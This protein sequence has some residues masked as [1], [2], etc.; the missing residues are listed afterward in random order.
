MVDIPSIFNKPDFLG[1]LLPG[2]IGIILAVVLF[3]PELAPVKQEQGMSLSM[4]FFSAVVFLVAGPAVGYTIRQLHRTLYRALTIPKAKRRTREQAVAQYYALRIAI[5]DSEKTEVDLSEGQYD[6]NISTGIIL[7]IVAVYFSVK[8][9][10][11]LE[12]RPLFMIGMGVVLFIAGYLERSDYLL[13]LKQLVVKYSL[14]VAILYNVLTPGNA[15]VAM[16]AGGYTRLGEEAFTS[17]SVLVGKKLK[18]WKVH[19]RKSG[20]PSGPITAKIR[21]NPGDKVSATFIESIE[22]SLLNSTNEEYTFTLANP[23]VINQGDRIMIEYN[24]PGEIEIEIW[25]VDKFDGTNTI[26]VAFDGKAYLDIGSGEVTG[27]MSSR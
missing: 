16:K 9:A 5:S 22:S 11:I 21:Q 2:Y 17:S 19:L 25:N 10:L 26:M 13:L 24:G 14:S 7:L 4:D 20:K 15:E 1:V 6:F 27:V 8:N 23:Y 18:S 12:W 3:F